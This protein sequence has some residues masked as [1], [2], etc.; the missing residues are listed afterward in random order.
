MKLPQGHHTHGSSKH[1]ST[2]WLLTLGLIPQTG[3]IGPFVRSCAI[4]YFLSPKADTHFTIPQRV[5]GW[6]DLDG[7][8][9]TAIL[10][11][12]EQRALRSQWGGICKLGEIRRICLRRSTNILWMRNCVAHANNVMCAQQ[13]ILKVWRQLTHIQEQSYQI[14]PDPKLKRQSLRL[15]WKASPLQEQECE[16]RRTIMGSAPNMKI[17]A[18]HM[19]SQQLAN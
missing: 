11:A 12:T 13:A 19:I 9:Y 10:L 7:W 14:Y 3:A 8:L 18:L 6:V 2:R 5:E 4:Y 16:Y 17:G 1:N 15:L